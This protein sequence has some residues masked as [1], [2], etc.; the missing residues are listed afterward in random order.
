MMEDELEQSKKEI[1]ALYENM[2]RTANMNPKLYIMPLELFNAI[3]K[4]LG[5]MEDRIKMQTASLK[6]H[7]DDKKYLNKRIRE[8]E[9]L[10][11]KHK[12]E[13]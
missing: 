4:R 9:K 3:M 10:L 7:R 6:R 12:I 2:E 8:L 11:P 5:H 13:K 1:A